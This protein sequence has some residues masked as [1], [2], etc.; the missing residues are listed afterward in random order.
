MHNR[1]EKK[2]VIDFIFPIALF[3]VFAACSLIVILLSANI[4]GNITKK[5]ASSFESRTVL[6]YLSEKMHQSDAQNNIS[7]GTLDGR[8][9]LM[10]RQQYDN[11]YYYTYIYEDDGILRE[12]FVPEG[13]SVS[14]SAG[15]E[16]TPVNSFEINE[17]SQGLFQFS[18]ISPEGEALTTIVSTKSTALD[19][20]P[21]QP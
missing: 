9:A 13:T 8:D 11:G 17:L 10:I 18:C 4:Y 1:T 12:L 2:H 14:A 6:S 5:S 20:Q 19:T 15:K 7:C 21:V 16:I 3:F